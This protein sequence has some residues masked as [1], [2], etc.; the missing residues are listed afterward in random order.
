[1]NVFD[2]EIIHFLN[3]FSNCSHLFD[4][5]VQFLAHNN[6]LKGGVLVAVMWGA[7]F[8][9]ND[10]YSDNRKYIIA[11]LISCLAA[12]TLGRG[13]QL[14]L[15]F[16]LR[17]LH[18]EGLNFI[19]PYGSSPESLTGWSSFP[20]DHAVLFF[21][22]STGLL[23]LSKRTAIFALLYTA[24]VISFPRMYLGLHYPTDIIAG[25]ILGMIV[26]LVGNIYLVKNESFHLITDWLI[27]KPRLFYPWLFLLTYQ[28]AT[29]FDDSR[30]IV[31]MWHKLLLM[32]LS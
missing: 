16:R 29:L 30:A 24:I 18:E 17:P 25:A 3:Q 6:L 12:I 9:S 5:G 10:H 22:L 4:V 11:T 27:S 31:L 32:I 2:V 21:C 15:P 20:S 23:F 19:L 26:A 1:M 14:I 8:K 13:L 28:I 7:W